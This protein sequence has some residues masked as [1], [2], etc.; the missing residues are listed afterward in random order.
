[1]SPDMAG[2]GFN[3]HNDANHFHAILYMRTESN[4]EIPPD[5]GAVPTELLH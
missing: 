2:F 4:G 1:M 3:P 5:Q